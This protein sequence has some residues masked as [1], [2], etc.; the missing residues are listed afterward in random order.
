MTIDIIGGGIG[1]LTLAISL[2]QHGYD[3][4]VF[5]RTQTIKPIGAGIILASNAMQVFDK[6]GLKQTIIDQGNSISSI[7][8]TQENLEP[9]S[10]V[11][12]SSFEKKFGVKNTAIHRGSLQQIL[13]KQIDS[14][15]IFLNHELSSISKTKEG[16]LLEFKN[17]KKIKSTITIGADGIH[18]VIRSKLFKKTE[19][20]MANQTCWRGVADFKLPAESQHELNEAWGKTGRFGFVQIA[21]CKVYW[22][23]LKTGNKIKFNGSNDVED[24]KDFKDFNPLV[25][26][27]IKATDPEKIHTAEISDFKPIKQWYNDN[28]CLIGD[29]AHAATPN[30][31]QGACQAIED[32]FVLSK[33]IAENPISVAFQAFQK[34][35]MTKALQVVNTSWRIGKIS[36]WK[37]TIAIQFRNGL[38]K[39]AL[40]SINKKQLETIFKLSEL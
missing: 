7:N 12:L 35:R 6:L 21:P 30:M 15:S 23:A 24:F 13:S 1:G 33:S 9:L 10:K 40:S 14:N 25:L 4:R 27:I 20:R 29:A 8:I 5:E 36:H 3:I 31:G 37:N 38:I 26:E 16:N 19:I 39:L 22:Y 28:V 32:A 11:D 2:K 34:I 17:G 18:S